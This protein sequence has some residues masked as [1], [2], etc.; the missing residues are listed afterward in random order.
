MGDEV[1][2]ASMILATGASSGIA[3]GT[4]YV[5]ACFDHIAVPRRTVPS[6]ELPKEVSKLEA[7]LD[8]AEREIRALQAEVTQA[9]GSRE[10]E[11]LAVQALMLRDPELRNEIV[12]RCREEQ[13]NVEAALRDTVERWGTAFGRIADPFFRE[14]AD[15]LRDVAGRL[16]NLL[17]APKQE[18]IREF[19]E[20]SIP[21]VGELLSTV[22]AGLDKARV[23]AL[24]AEKGGPTAHA[25]I[26]ARSLGIPAVTDVENATT[27]IKTGDRLLVDGV[28]GRVF[29]NPGE[30]VE[31]EYDRLEADFKMRQ[32]ALLETILLPA[33]TQDG[34]AITLNANVGKVADAAAAAGFHADGV[35]L[36]RTEF[37]FLVQ[38]QLPTEEEQLRIFRNTADRMT[39]RPV[40]IRVLDVGSDKVLRYFPLSHESNPSLG[41]RGTRLML[42]HPEI[43]RPQLR[44]ILRLSATHA[45]SIL[46]PMIPD[47]EALVEVKR[48]VQGVQDELQA[49]G[50]R[51]N[52][53]IRIGAMIE[54]PSAAIMARWIAREADFLSIGSNDLIQYLLTTDRT[55]HEMAP[56]YEPLHPAVVRILGTVIDAA[57]SEG[58]EISLCGE[59]SGN[60]AYTKLLLG[61]GLRSLSVAPGELLEIKRVIRSVSMAGAR[62]LA[63]RV[64]ES[65]TVR[66]VKECLARDQ[67]LTAF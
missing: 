20:G 48:I 6:S 30:S 64:L 9:A 37:V 5:C 15:D 18:R 7:V 13:I 3:R 19:P 28:A 56:Y 53:K 43:L 33:V 54:T 1:Q 17:L 51:F 10:A 44:A 31:R 46:F 63:G 8:E 55:S 50:H 40:V 42:R 39:P 11:I 60:P 61:L 41:Q 58:K 22:V 4:A 62:E 26:L 25:V 21:V 36:Y 34:V 29:V 52:P 38:D 27:R 24:L 14:R 32:D 35:G 12:A 45:V 67:A 57:R 49:E 66:G 2:D 47:V 65:S 16:L 23:R 59:M